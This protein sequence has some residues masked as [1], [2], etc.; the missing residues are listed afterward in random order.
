M[1]ESLGYDVQELD[2]IQFANIDLRGLK[3]GEWRHLTTK[4]I[5]ELKKTVES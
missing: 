2:R 4:E 3:R 5:G 1:F